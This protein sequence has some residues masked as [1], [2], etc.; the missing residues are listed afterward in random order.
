MERLL[1]EEGASG[2]FFRQLMRGVRWRGAVCLHS[3]MCSRLGHLHR[4]TKV[5]I[6]RGARRIQNLPPPHMM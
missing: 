3:N 2:F 6:C 5:S 1:F 4:A